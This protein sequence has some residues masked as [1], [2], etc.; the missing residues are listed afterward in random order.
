MSTF[1]QDNPVVLFTLVC[2]GFIIVISAIFYTLY[3]NAK[4]GTEAIDQ[5]IP[6]TA[7]VLKVGHSE[8]SGGGVDVNLTFEVMPP[9]GLPYTVTTVWTVEPLSISKIQEGSTVAIKI[10]AK[11][12]KEIYSMED[13]A[14][15]LGQ[16]HPDPKS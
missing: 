14:W 11:D 5:G 7:K 1:L 10:N 15:A 12:H 13:W 2:A 8:S 6:A 3:M 16:M 9:S 4:K